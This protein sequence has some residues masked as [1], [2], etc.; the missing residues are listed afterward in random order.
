LFE[1][2]FVGIET[3][4]AI[5]Y[6]NFELHAMPRRAFPDRRDGILDSSRHIEISERPLMLRVGVD[7]FVAPMLSLSPLPAERYPTLNPAAKTEGE[8]AG[9]VP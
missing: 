7:K 5:I 6:L 3:S 9:G 2:T 4:D 8:D 1:L